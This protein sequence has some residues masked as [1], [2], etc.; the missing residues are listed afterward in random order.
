M[1]QTWVA[2]YELAITIDT[3]TVIGLTANSYTSTEGPAFLA[4]PTFGSQFQQG[5][6]G[7][8][9]K[10]RCQLPGQVVGVL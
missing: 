6:A 4:K 3:D 9:V 5:I 8:P 10:H 1:S 7:P 2:G